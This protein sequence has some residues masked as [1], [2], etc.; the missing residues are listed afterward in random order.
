MLTFPCG[1]R[2]GRKEAKIV[3]L[4][5]QRTA[6]GTQRRREI[7]VS[8]QSSVNPSDTSLGA[9]HPRERV[10][11]GPSLIRVS[12]ASAQST[13]AQRLKVRSPWVPLPHSDRRRGTRQLFQEALWSPGRRTMLAL[14][15]RV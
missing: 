6:S 5:S 8:R 2:A 9:R 15:S 10:A 1:G 4:G 12:A 11:R 3:L 14:R 7:W 13:F